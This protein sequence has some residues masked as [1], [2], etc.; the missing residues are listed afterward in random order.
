[1]PKKITVS[2]VLFLL[3]GLAACFSGTITREY[4]KQHEFD[5]DEVSVE[6]VNGKIFIETWDEDGVDVYAEIQVRASNKRDARD[7]MENVEIVVRKRNDRL[8]I[9]VEKPH[10]GSGGF[11]DWISG[12]GKPNVTVNFAIKV[13]EEMNIEASSVNGAVD[14][15]GVEGKLSLSTT[16]GKITA[17]AIAGAVEA[18]TTNG[19]IYVDISTSDLMDGVSLNTVNGSVKLALD[20]DIAADVEIST[21]NG[22]INTDFPLEVRGKWGP[23][24]VSG[25]INGGG[26]LIELET[27]NGSVS[28]IER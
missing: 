24:N 6:T 27:V 1:M 2:F 9:R 10:D 4:H 26:E 25:E 7:F 5:G 22:S 11:W 8:D 21:V 17:E 13:P 16:N 3:V 20:G 28:I 12:V 23:K 15:V 18:S 14:V 19:S